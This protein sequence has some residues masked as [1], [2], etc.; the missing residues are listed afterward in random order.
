MFANPRIHGL[1]TSVD[2]G[3]VLHHC[4]Q[5]LAPGLA[6]VTVVTTPLD[7]YTHTVCRAMS[8]MIPLVRVHKTDAFYAN[9]AAFNKGLAMEEARQQ[10]PWEDWIL[11]FDA[12]I[13]IDMLWGF[14]ITD[15][16]RGFLYGCRRRLATSYADVG[17]LTAPVIPD[18]RVGYGYFQLFHS[19]DP[20]VQKS[21]LLD[22]HWRH[23]GNYDSNF[24]LSFGDRVRELPINLWHLGPRSEN[25]FGKGRERE[26]LEMQERRAG[27]GIHPSERL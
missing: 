15:I 12:D 8:S 23:A 21:P 16:R 20:A 7:S 18:D 3:E 5:R 4:L 25:L 27:K 19:T 26:F 14:R 11:F 10:M 22:T 9:G 17:D 24:L 1:V 6:S 13:L 2:Y